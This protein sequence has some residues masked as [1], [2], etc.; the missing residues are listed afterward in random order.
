MIFF[1]CRDCSKVK[2]WADINK[3]V[4]HLYCHTFRLDYEILY[5]DNK[6]LVSYAKSPVMQT[7][8]VTP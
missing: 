8:F 7:K 6:F 1:P 3:T 5:R 2:R 4:D